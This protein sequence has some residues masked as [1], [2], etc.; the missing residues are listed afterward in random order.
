[1]KLNITPARS[2]VFWIHLVCGVAAGISV[3]V[4]SFTGVT[5]AFD[6]QVIAWA[7][8]D[9]VRVEPRAMDAPRLSLA[10][11]S[12]R[13]RTAF[14]GIELSGITLSSNLRDA[15]L[16]TRGRGETYYVNPYSGETH[17]A[18]PSGTRAF[19][20]T[21]TNWHRYLGMSGEQ[22]GIG[23][24]VNGA[25]HCAFLGLALTGLYIWFSRR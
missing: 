20:R 22:R 25:S 21:M 9:A 5:L 16:F 6:K 3:A 1:M 15:V 14:R 4:M 8:R 17:A 11:M 10:E 18:G 12:G 7:A 2:I 23:K 24:A 13:F 19:M